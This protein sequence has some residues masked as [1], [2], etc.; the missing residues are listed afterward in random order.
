MRITFVIALFALMTS[1]AH[2]P[3]ARVK[4]ARPLTAEEARIIE[5]ARQAVA[6]NDT[7]VARAEFEVPQRRSEGGWAVLVWRLPATP[8][9]FRL[10]TIDET[11]RVTAYRH[12]Y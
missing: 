1:C 4:T 10:I 6:T 5:I 8:G 12:G 7:W 3:T 2:Q 9:G 11:D